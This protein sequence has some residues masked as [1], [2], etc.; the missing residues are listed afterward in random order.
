MVTMPAP[1]HVR[2]VAAL[3]QDH[4]RSRGAQT[5]ELRVFLTPDGRL[6]PANAEVEPPVRRMQ[7][8]AVIWSGRLV[9]ADAGW[10]L[11]AV[12]G[13]DTPLWYFSARRLHPGEHLTLHAPEGYDLVYRVVNVTTVE[14]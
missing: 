5:L 4:R 1:H 8:G 7:A 2:I 6:A 14:A 11:R 9:T 10:A 13:E 3:T 12:N